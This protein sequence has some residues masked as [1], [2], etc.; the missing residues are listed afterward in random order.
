ML[1]SLKDVIFRNPGTTPVVIRATTAEGDIAFV[2]TSN[3]LSV[4]VSQTLMKTVQDI[5]GENGI[6]IIPNLE[7]PQPRKQ[8]QNGAKN[9]WRSD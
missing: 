7:V 8:Y 2:G 4:E 6:H 3:K 9:G 1:A 5:I